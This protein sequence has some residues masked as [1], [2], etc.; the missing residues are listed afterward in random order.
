M[1]AHT[2]LVLKHLDVSIFGHAK[3]D[4]RCR[5]NLRKSTTAKEEYQ[6][7]FTICEL[8]KYS[9]NFCVNPQNDTPFF[10]RTGIWSDDT[11]IVD[12]SMIR[13]TDFIS[14]HIS[15]KSTA[16]LATTRSVTT[17]LQS[18]RSGS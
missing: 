2:S 10:R 16:S 5:L 14:S 12:L 13:P 7:I 8:L 6:D 4:F 18:G 17:M 15:I 11:E 9:Y 3:E 1:P